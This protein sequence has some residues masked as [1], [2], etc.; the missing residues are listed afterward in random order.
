MKHLRLIAAGA[1]LCMLAACGTA[2]STSPTVDTVAAQKMVLE[3]QIGYEALL[4]VAVAYNKRPRCT[5]PRTVV[6]CSDPAIV[7][8]LRTV[9][10]QI[11]SG[12]T[13]AMNIASTPGVTTSAVTAAIAVATQGIPTL[14]TILDSINKGA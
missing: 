14:Q 11:V 7:A 6:T 3:A 4:T 12:F 8:K 13:A 10:T 9:N 1:L 2:P 5:E